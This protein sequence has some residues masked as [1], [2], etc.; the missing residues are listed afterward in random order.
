MRKTLEPSD[1]TA[2]IDSREQRPLDLA[3]L[4]VVRGGLTT[5]DYGIAGLEG[6]IA[7]ERKSL[8]DLV[9]CIGPSRE[10][11]EREI[12]RL[13]AY[14]V[15]AVIVE[16]TWADLHAGFWRSRVTPASAVGSVLGWIAEGVPFLFVGN[17]HEAGRA[18]ARMLFIAARR[19]WRQVH[20]FGE[21]MS[22]PPTDQIG[23]KSLSKCESRS[24]EGPASC[25][26]SHIVDVFPEERLG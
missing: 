15:R 22:A 12:K 7:I 6:Q 4:K 10:R 24:I 9:S 19:S 14:P 25:D 23:K 3:P 20:A 8:D 18:V 2:I 1:V 11:F 17:H 21:M 26:S 16:A 13:L 5:G